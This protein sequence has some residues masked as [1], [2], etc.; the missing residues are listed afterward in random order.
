LRKLES[1]S[2]S[3]ELFRG[4][5]AAWLIGIEYGEGVWNAIRP[6]KMMVG[7]NQV[8]PQA[9]RGFGAAARSM[10]SSRRS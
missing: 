6:R 10:T 7:N 8:D 1:Y 2:G 5:W 4:I 9:V 3:A